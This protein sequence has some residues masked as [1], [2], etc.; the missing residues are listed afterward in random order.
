[1]AATA[2]HYDV[3][4]PAEPG[5]RVS[6]RAASKAAARRRARNMLGIEAGAPLKVKARR[7][8]L[9]SQKLPDEELLRAIIDYE[10]LLVSHVPVDEAWAAV[11]ARGEA[12]RLRPGE[13]PSGALLRAKADPAACA[14]MAAGE[15]AQRPAD[16]A[17]RAAEYLF[18]RADLKEKAIMPALLAAASAAFFTLLTLALPIVSVRMLGQLESGLVT[19]NHNPVSL[20]LSKAHG[21]YTLG[22]MPD[23]L[24][25]ILLAAMIAGGCFALLKLPYEM[26]SRVPLL[27]PLQDIRECERVVAW[28]SIYLPFHT[29]RATYTQFCEAA[30]EAVKTGPLAEGFRLL[31]SE[32]RAGLADSISTGIGRRPEAV[33]EACRSPL[34]KISRLPNEAG[35]Q[36]VES[37]QQATTR[38]MRRH[39]QRAKR[40]AGA[41]KMAATIAAIGGVALGA[42]LPLMSMAA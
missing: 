4:P 36:L 9:L 24:G 29:G 22:G 5:R 38:S 34:A 3:F 33:P 21:L 40:Q 27:G 15:L 42:Y 26:A 30:A 1:M 11:A 10:I 14:I 20:F 37:V 28:L 25:L 2:T 13:R 8:P 17:K 41:M 16:G 35:A 32:A 31:R 18:E 12:G 6:V 19:I 7:N 39:S 23:W